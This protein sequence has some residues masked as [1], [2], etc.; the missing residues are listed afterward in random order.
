MP[1]LVCDSSEQSDLVGELQV[2]PI[3]HG[4]QSTVVVP[5]VVKKEPQSEK[6]EVL[7][8]NLGLVPEVR[9]HVRAPLLWSSHCPI[10]PQPSFRAGKDGF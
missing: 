5:A 1:V 3:V 4:A 9:V 7:V 8:C 2:R 10:E 6:E